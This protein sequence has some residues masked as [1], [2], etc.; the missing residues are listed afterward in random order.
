MIISRWV[1]LRMRT[2]SD[3]SVQKIK[4]P[5][6]WS[7]LFFSANRAVKWY[8]E[9]YCKAGKATYDNMAHARCM[10]DDLGYK[11]THR[12]CNTYC[13]FH[14][15]NGCTNAPQR[16]AIL[17]AL[18]YFAC[19]ASWATNGVP[20]NLAVWKGSTD[21]QVQKALCQSKPLCSQNSGGEGEAGRIRQWKQYLAVL[22]ARTSKAAKE[23]LI[24]NG[25]AGGRGGRSRV[26]SDS[27][28]S[29]NLVRSL[30]ATA[31]LSFYVV[32]TVQC[33]VTV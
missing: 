30:I 18:F 25:A 14:S 33:N 17:A 15:K 7:I 23:T 16:Y 24:N 13:V 10:V 1:L 11:H 27:V 6:L 31:I 21:R 8:L 32:C 26:S 3:K 22:L 20:W 4:T 5:V 12:I 19:C 2:V 29:R 9:K 28:A